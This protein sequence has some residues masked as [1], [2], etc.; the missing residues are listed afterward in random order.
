MSI[1]KEHFIKYVAITLISIFIIISF[2]LGIDVYTNMNNQEINQTI[3]IWGIT[4]D[5]ILS[6]FTIFGIIIG[7]IWAMYQ[8]DKNKRL[9]QQEKGSLIAMKFSEKLI[10]EIS[11]VNGVLSKIK[12]IEKYVLSINPEHI[13]KFDTNELLSVISKK[14]IIKDYLNIINSED[15]QNKYEKYL[16]KCFSEPEKKKFPPKFYH[17]ITNLLN[18]LEYICM[19]ISS[20]TAGS[21]YI[22]PS[23]HQI[24]L[25]TVHILYINI[26]IQNNNYP[27]K[28]YINIIQVYNDWN[29][30]RNKE[31]DEYNNVK[32]KIQKIN[33]STNKKI[34]RINKRKKKETEKIRNKRPKAV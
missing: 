20:N 34:E 33:K 25:D 31:Q 16:D 1:F 30:M 4:L 9:K 5:N 24:F 19:D 6:I 13:S 2:T 27:D 23:L 21:Q 22:Y 3:L 32:N 8:Y 7:A 12:F 15:V 26:A 28:Y 14:Q 11:I 18:E 29:Y 17:L 10:D